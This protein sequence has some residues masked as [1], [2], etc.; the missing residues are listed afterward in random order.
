MSSVE[1]CLNGLWKFH[2][3]R[4]PDQT[5]PGFPDLDTADREGIVVPGHLQLQGQDRPQYTI[6]EYQW[7]GHES[8]E[9]GQVPRRHN[10]VASNTTG[11]TPS[12]FDLTD[13]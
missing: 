3:A 9:P 2:H 11:F 12:E 10:P 13:P 4:N 5:L 7:D 8:V 1:Q 6:V